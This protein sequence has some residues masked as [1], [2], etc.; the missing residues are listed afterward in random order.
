MDIEKKLK[1]RLYVAIGYVIA[2]IIVIVFSATTHTDNDFLSGLGAG[3]LVCGGTR[4]R[5]YFLITKNAETI[6]RQEIAETDERN[7]AI[8]TKAKNIAF[9]VYIMLACIAIIVLSLLG[10]ESLYSVLSLSVCTMLII[11]CSAYW[12]IRKRC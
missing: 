7:L 3:L 1:Y 4:I 9:S 5:N 2:A 11:Y 6:K 12:I 10:Y 8:A